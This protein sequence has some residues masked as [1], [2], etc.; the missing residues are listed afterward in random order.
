[1][2]M[3]LL[4]ASG[5]VRVVNEIKYTPTP[6]R[7]RNPRRQIKSSLGQE[8]CAIFAQIG[9]ELFHNKNVNIK[10]VKEYGEIK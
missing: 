2:C 8:I 10:N 6:F 5:I 4:S 3:S 7:L 9:R 1:M